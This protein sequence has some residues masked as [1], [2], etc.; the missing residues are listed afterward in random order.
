[1]GLI[2]NEEKLHQTDD[3]SAIDEKIKRYEKLY[4]EGT[5]D[6]IME[7]AAYKKAEEKI[8]NKKERI[9]NEIQELKKTLAGGS[10][11]TTKDRVAGILN[12]FPHTRNSDVALTIKYWELFQR[13]IYHPD[14]VKPADL[15]K[16]ERLTTVARIRAKIQNEYGLFLANEGVRKHRRKREETVREDMLTDVPELPVI[17]VYTDETGKTDDYVIVGAVWFLNGK[18]TFDLYQII[19][20]WKSLKNVKK[21]IHFARC[22]KSDLHTYK[23]FTDIVA[24]N[25]E[26]LSFKLIAVPRA[27]TSRKIDEIV[28]KLYEHMIIKGI[29][30][31]INNGRVSLPRQIGLTIDQQDGIDNISQAELQQRLNDIFNN[32]FGPETTIREITS[33]DSKKS[34]FLQIADLISGAINRK[35][36]HTGERNYKD[37]LADYIIDK[38]GLSYREDEVTEIDATAFI[39][40]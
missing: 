38:L 7:L 36:N 35:L 10:Y 4:G 31:E 3:K 15:F 19:S 34:Y 37:E 23:E 2:D 8:K 14:A 40:L 33:I 12:L 27:G 6:E 5:I 1:M 16:L 17:E 30:H 21:E 20:A 28:E 25:R 29:E 32:R 39:N 13:D 11:E 24:D 26:Y 18:S 9:D 22:G